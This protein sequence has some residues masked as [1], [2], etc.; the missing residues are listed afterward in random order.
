MHLHEQV[1][2]G[3]SVGAR[4]AT[5]AH[6][7][8]LSVAHTLGYAH[9]DLTRPVH[10][11]LAPT[12]VAR[13][14][15]DG[16]TTA[17]RGTRPAEGE[18]A[19]VLLDRSAAVTDRTGLGN[20][21][22]RCTRTGAVRTAH[23]R[24]DLHRGGRTCDRGLEGHRERRL[25][26]GAALGPGGRSRRGPATT[27]E[28][29]DQVTQVRSL[30]SGG[31]AASGRETTHAAGHRS[32]RAHFVVLLALVG[33]AYHLIGRGHLLEAL[34]GRVVTRV[35]VGVQPPGELAVCRG[36]LFRGGILRHTEHLVVVLLEPLPI[37]VH[38]SSDSTGQPRTLTMAA[39]A[40][41]PFHR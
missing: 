10:H 32:H 8:A 9:L 3:T 37:D 23:V 11:P 39:R 15:D 30:E 24:G 35:R 20:R 27:E 41:R 34:L 13:G 5:A 12:G 25:Q 28:V 2:V 26:V 7:D 1:A 21:A 31:A 6:P 36:D 40:T 17:A 18:E 4:S 16:P 38:V 14:L 19:L 29:S 33:I 22:R